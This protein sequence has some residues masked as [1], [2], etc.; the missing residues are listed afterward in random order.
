MKLSLQTEMTERISARAKT[1]GD[2]GRQEE[3]EMLR[4]FSGKRV[5]ATPCGRKLLR[6]FYQFITSRATF[7]LV[8]ESWAS[9]SEGKKKRW[10]LHQSHI[11]CHVQNFNCIL[12]L[13]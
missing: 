4:R 1:A 3:A 6:I 8:H 9:H 5:I 13:I 10:L 7:M 2:T 12:F 11:H